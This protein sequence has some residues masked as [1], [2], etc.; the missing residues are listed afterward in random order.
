M[1]KEVDDRIKH[2]LKQVVGLFDER[3]R[4]VRDRQIRTWR[5]LKLL[6][7]NIQHTYYSEVAHDWRIPDSERAGED[8]DQ[9]YYDKPINVFRAYLESIIAALSVTVPPVKC[10][11]DDADNSLDLATA[12]AG[13]KIAS[14]VYRHNNVSLLWL[15]AL[16]IYCTEGI[17]ACYNYPKSDVKYGTYEEKK[18]ETIEEPHEYTR[19]PSCG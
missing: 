16:F 19:C 3:D 2:L 18:Y 9:A 10:F 17:V 7:E 1:A 15:H 13:D 5:R 8:T 11:P 12:R 14:L 6:W 4:A